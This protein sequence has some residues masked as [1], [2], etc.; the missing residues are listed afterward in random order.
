MTAS[1]SDRVALLSA[2]GLEFVTERHLATL[3]T[4]RPD[5]S[6]HVTPVG[7]T[8]DEAQDRAYVICSG[9]SRKARNVDG[10]GPVALCQLDGRRWLTV[11]GI[12][13]VSADPA[14]VADAVSRYASRYRQPRVN[15]ARV[16]II[17]MVNRVL[18]SAELLG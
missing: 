13:R 5:G 8:W 16:A 12:G 7:F 18:G 17:I 15:P 6:P 9:T 4:M 11:E 2:A 10:G 14:D 1:T 3:T